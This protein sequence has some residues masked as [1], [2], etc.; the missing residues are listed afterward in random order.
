MMENQ[1]KTVQNGNMDIYEKVRC[2]PDKSKYDNA[3]SDQEAQKPQEVVKPVIAP[4]QPSWKQAVAFMASSP[5]ELLFQ[6]ANASAATNMRLIARHINNILT[7]VFT[8]CSV[9]LCE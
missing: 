5:V 4:E 3:E 8:E 1:N 7:G 6:P 2:V 9:W